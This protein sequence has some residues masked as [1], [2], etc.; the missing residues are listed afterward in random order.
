LYEGSTH[1]VPDVDGPAIT[2]A[3]ALMADEG[4]GTYNTPSK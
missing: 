4:S 3:T 2:D 1:L